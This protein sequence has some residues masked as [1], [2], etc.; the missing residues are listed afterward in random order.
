M[1]IG[2]LH[3]NLL[4]TYGLVLCNFLFL[5]YF[6]LSFYIYLKRILGYLFL[7]WDLEMN[8]F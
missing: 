8:F 6:I 2:Y 1:N 4:C 5:I 3:S 7:K